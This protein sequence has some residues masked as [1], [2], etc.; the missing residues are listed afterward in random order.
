MRTHND[1]FMPYRLPKMSSDS[2]STAS[3]LDVSSQTL[4]MDSSDDS[5]DPGA[6]EGQV[7]TGFIEVSTTV[8]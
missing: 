2:G 4:E 8:P 1:Y 5:K 7:S 6:K 3:K